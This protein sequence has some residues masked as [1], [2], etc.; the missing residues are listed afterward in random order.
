[1]KDHWGYEI[2]TCPE[3]GS[4]VLPGQK[5]CS[6]CGRKLGEKMEEYLR[7]IVKAFGHRCSECK[8]YNAL[9]CSNPNVKGSKSK[10]VIYGDR[11][12][13]MP[14]SK[15]CSQFDGEDDYGDQTGSD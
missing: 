15:A 10:E 14:D 4:R 8:Y 11:S 3:C 5:Y 13:M 1:M 2:L 9:H 6:E 12:Y 7:G